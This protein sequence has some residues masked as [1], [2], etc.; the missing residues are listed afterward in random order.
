MHPDNS[1]LFVWIFFGFCGLIVVAQLFPAIIM[2]MG[3]LKSFKK[4]SVAKIQQLLVK[5]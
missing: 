2:L 3:M 4:N 5:F 1:S